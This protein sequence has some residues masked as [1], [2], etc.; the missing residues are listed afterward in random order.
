MNNVVGWSCCK[1]MK[2]YFIHQGVPFT[3]FSVATVSVIV[4]GV[5]KLIVTLYRLQ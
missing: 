2:I 1:S 3:L 4:S 5:L